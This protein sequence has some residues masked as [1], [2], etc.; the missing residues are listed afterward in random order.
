MLPCFGVSS[1]AAGAIVI[2]EAMAV[3]NAAAHGPERMTD[4]SR[5]AFLVNDKT[6][7][8]L[9]V[10]QPAVFAQI[11]C[12]SRCT[13]DKLGSA[14]DCHDVPCFAVRYSS[15]SRVRVGARGRCNDAIG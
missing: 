9:L 15:L 13:A 10:D 3:P 1:A 8:A 11:G 4:A 5:L 2:T 12:A 6:Q 7:A 14:G